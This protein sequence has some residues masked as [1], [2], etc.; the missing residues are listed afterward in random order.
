MD[1]GEDVDQEIQAAHGAEAEKVSQ[2]GDLPGDAGEVG[3]LNSLI[4]LL[5]GLGSGENEWERRFHPF[6]MGMVRKSHGLSL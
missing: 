6:I 5:Q 1:L 2:A 4:S 3:M